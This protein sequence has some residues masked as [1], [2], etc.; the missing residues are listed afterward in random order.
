MKMMFFLSIFLC[1]F[2]GKAQLLEPVSNL[3]K[4]SSA[5]TPIP[6]IDYTARISQYLKS[7]RTEVLTIQNTNYKQVQECMEKLR[8]INPNLSDLESLYNRCQKIVL[9]GIQGSKPKL[10]SSNEKLNVEK[11]HLIELN[12]SIPKENSPSGKV[13]ELSADVSNILIHLGSQ[14]ALKDKENEIGHKEWL[15]ILANVSKFE[16]ASKAD[17]F[18]APCLVESFE[19]QQNI[20]IQTEHNF[21]KPNEFILVTESVPV[22]NIESFKWENEFEEVF[23]YKIQSNNQDEGKENWLLISKLKNH[24]SYKI[25][26][27]TIIK[28]QP[29]K[30]ISFNYELKNE[31]IDLLIQSISLP[32]Q[33]GTSFEV[34][35]G[36]AQQTQLIFKQKLD[37]RGIGFQSHVAYKDVIQAEAGIIYSPFDGKTSSFVS[38][39]VYSF[40]LN[41]GNNF[42][43]QQAGRLSVNY[44]KNDLGVGLVTN[45]KSSPQVQVSKTIMKG[46]GRL[47]A[48]TDFVHQQNVSLIVLFH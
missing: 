30:K 14:E 28:D 20:K 17:P 8:S 18:F 1:S 33:I 41:Y 13:H 15:S 3:T 29:K 43:S 40:S 23:L 21:L 47:N 45:F 37:E 25:A 26:R 2:W 27:Y 34:N 11:I 7:A 4:S 16:D 31:D 9:E 24:N 36:K 44:Q 12:N 10:K 5:P 42:S 6:T 32:K 22:K 19:D 48:S 39:K 35:V 46:K 38:A